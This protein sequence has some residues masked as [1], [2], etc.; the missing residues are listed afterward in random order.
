[1]DHTKI[2]VDKTAI[3]KSFN[4]RAV[5]VVNFAAGEAVG[6]LDPQG[7]TGRLV[8]GVSSRVR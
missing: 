3:R 1:M 2:T 5:E 8:P 7:T 6:Q 4:I